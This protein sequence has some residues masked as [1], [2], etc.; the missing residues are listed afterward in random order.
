MPDP[1]RR[2]ALDALGLALRAGR[3]VVGTRSVADAARAGELELVVWA[4]DASG[5][6][7]GR[8]SGT[9]R[10]AAPVEVTLGD[11]GALGDAVGRGPVVVVGVSDPGL[12]RKIAGLAGDGSADR[13]DGPPERS[14]ARREE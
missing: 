11:R 8:I 4:E 13:Q 6:A 5:N 1:S 14:A 3:A 12:A 7:R 9:L 2:R 10:D